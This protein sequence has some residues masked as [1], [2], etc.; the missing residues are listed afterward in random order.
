M[1]MRKDEAAKAVTCHLVECAVALVSL[2]RGRDVARQQDLADELG[3][4]QQTISKMLTGELSVSAEFALGI[5]RAT[6][7]KITAAAL[8][9]DLPWPEPA[10][11]DEQAAETRNT[12]EQ[13][14]TASAG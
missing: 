10:K 11:A 13:A 14:A 1:M 2:A 8:R 6:G 7:G 9:P 4:V 3:C 12:E 5:E